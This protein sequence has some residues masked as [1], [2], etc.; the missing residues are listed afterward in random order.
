MTT[1]TTLLNAIA[2]EL[3]TTDKEMVI[4][5]ALAMI[6]KTGV[7]VDAAFD[8]L[9]GEGAFVKFA[10]QVYDALRAKAA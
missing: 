5:V 7:A 10:G 9:L 8:L 1:P 4:N 3:N 6:V 2:A